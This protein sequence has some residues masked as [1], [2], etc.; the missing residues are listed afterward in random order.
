MSL[1]TLDRISDSRNHGIIIRPSDMGT[2]IS[3][4][5]EFRNVLFQTIRTIPR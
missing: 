5:R 4:L 1:G 3:G 2:H